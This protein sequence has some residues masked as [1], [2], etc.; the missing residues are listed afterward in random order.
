MTGEGY[1][2]LLLILGGLYLLGYRLDSP[3]DVTQY[4]RG[5][6]PVRGEEE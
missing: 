5:Y 1:L 6:V 3:I 2:L 4:S